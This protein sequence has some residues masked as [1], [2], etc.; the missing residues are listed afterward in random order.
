[1]AL[2]TITNGLSGLTTRS[3][4]NAAISAINGLT[5]PKVYY[6]ESSGDNGTAEAGNPTKPYQTGTAAYNAG[7]ATGNPFVINFGFGAFTVTLTSGFNNLCRGFNGVGF[8]SSEATSATVVTIG[9]TPSDVVNEDAPHGY[10][11]NGLSINNLLLIVYADGANTTVSDGE[12]NTGGNGGLIFVTGTG[13]LVAYSRGGGE[14]PTSTDGSVT[15]GTS[16]SITASGCITVLGAYN[17]AK[18]VTTGT[19]GTSGDLFFDGCDLRSGDFLFGTISA[20]RCSYVSS[21]TLDND[22]GGNALW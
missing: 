10:D 5:I 14:A 11:V 19:P 15:G 7:V 4:L 8:F 22:K 3:R 6:V 20:G 2:S 17:T 13:A 18:S 16:G 21:L 9:A 1:M 12:T